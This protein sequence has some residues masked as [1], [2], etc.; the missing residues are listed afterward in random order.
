[1]MVVNYKL[2]V[3]RTCR[4]TYYRIGDGQSTNDWYDS[5]S[6]NPYCPSTYKI[7]FLQL[8]D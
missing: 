4:Y 8:V 2:L 6:H 5:G 7:N 1:M 3:T